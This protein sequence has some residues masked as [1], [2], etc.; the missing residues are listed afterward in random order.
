MKGTYKHMTSKY[1][2]KFVHNDLHKYFKTLEADTP[3]MF[4]MDNDPSQT[5]KASM[6]ALDDI[7][8][9]SPDVNVIE[10][11]FH[12]LKRK[13]ENDAISKHLTKESLATF[14]QRVLD[15]LKCAHISYI[16]FDR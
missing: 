9:D 5:S 14:K 2:S 7:G 12:V 8:A 10:D 1:F 15:T 13:L 16:V 3:W 11:Y 4:V 6:D